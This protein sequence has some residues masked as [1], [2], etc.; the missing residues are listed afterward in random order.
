MHAVTLIKDDVTLDEKSKHTLHTAA[1]Q[2]Y[3]SLNVTTLLPCHSEQCHAEDSNNTVGIPSLWCNHHHPLI[4]FVC[5]L[6]DSE[7]LP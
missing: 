2:H 4:L 5:F 6:S 3:T 1:A 7:T